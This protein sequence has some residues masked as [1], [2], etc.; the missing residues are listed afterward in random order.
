MIGVI[1]QA[2][3]DKELAHGGLTEL[4]VVGS[5]HGGR[6]DGGPVRRVSRS[7]GRGRYAGGVFR[8]VDVGEL[9]LHA[10]PFGLLD[11]AGFFEPLLAF[12]DQLVSS[13]SCGLSIEL[14]CSWTV[15]RTCCSR[16]WPLTGQP[17]S[18]SGSTADRREPTVL[19][20]PPT[21]P[22]SWPPL[23]FVQPTAGFFDR[24][25]HG[26]AFASNDNRTLSWRNAKP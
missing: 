24:S 12:L 22:E 23:S 19:G 26:F 21:Y 6:P 1:P 25:F 9:G 7:A 5:M 16:K 17:M 2:L 13:G 15:T 4:H 20:C 18:R 14:C 10:K 11:V 3:V 8:G